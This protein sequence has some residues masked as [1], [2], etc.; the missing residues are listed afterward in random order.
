MLLG[1]GLRVFERDKRV[2]E[3]EGTAV[4]Q[5][6]C[7]Q[8]VIDNVICQPNADVAIELGGKGA[9]GLPK[10]FDGPKAVLRVSATDTAER[11]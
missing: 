11:S 8:V 10:R 5:K 2:I 9:V 1:Y 4:F 7:W 3:L 6:R